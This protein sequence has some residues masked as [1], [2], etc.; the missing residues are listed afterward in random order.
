[1]N[2]RMDNKKKFD[3]KIRFLQFSKRNL[4]PISIQCSY[5]TQLICRRILWDILYANLDWCIKNFGSPARWVLNIRA[6]RKNEHF[7]IHYKWSNSLLS[8]DISVALFGKIAH[9]LR[10]WKI[11]HLRHKK[12]NE[13]ILNESAA[14]LL[15]CFSA[16]TWANTVHECLS[17]CYECLFK[18]GSRKWSY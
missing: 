6:N 8:D 18:N 15:A 16:F 2:Y 17:Q 1:M 5:I 12:P 3:I 13:M 10:S 14:L 11:Y 4:N 7:P 9:W